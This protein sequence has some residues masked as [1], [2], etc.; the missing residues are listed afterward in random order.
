MDTRTLLRGE[1]LPWSNRQFA[2]AAHRGTG[3]G[4]PE[5]SIEAIAQAF[6]FGADIVEVGVRRARDGAFV[7]I[8]DDY[9]DRTTAAT[10]RIADT[11]IA[12]LRD[13]P[14]RAGAGGQQ[15]PLTRWT[16]PTLNESLVD[17]RGQGVLSLDAKYRSDV[18]ALAQFVGALAAQHTT[19]LKAE[20]QSVEEA[21]HLRDR[22]G[23]MA[24]FVP[25]IS[26]RATAWL[27]A[28]INDLR[29]LGLAC[30]EIRCGSVA[31]L[32]DAAIMANAQRAGVWVNTLASRHIP[33]MDDA[34][35]CAEPSTVWGELASHGAT[36]IQT[37]E[38]EE[39]GLLRTQLRKAA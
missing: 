12:D 2:I 31:E 26:T 1:Q 29:P 22:I 9:L 30:F 38:I 8:E 33:G 14:L 17:L 35:A 16:L 23:D 28:L 5:N 18:P 19:I 13:L 24:Q 20:I 27:P 37:D 25:I 3:Q 36:V 10:G 32:H 15:A 34:R 6:D 4:L 21:R 11:D 7:I 39:L